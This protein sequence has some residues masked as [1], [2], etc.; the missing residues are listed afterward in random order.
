MQRPASRSFSTTAG[1]SCKLRSCG[2]AELRPE[3]ALLLLKRS[4]RSSRL[5]KPG[6]RLQRCGCF[7]SEPGKLENPLL[8]AHFFKTSF[9]QLQIF[10]RLR[11]TSRG[12]ALEL[13]GTA[14]E[15]SSVRSEMKT[16]S[17]FT[18]A[19]RG[20]SPTNFHRSVLA[21]YDV[22]GLMHEFLIGCCLHVGSFDA[23]KLPSLA[24]AESFCQVC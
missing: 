5:A 22:Y 15:E 24:L 11:A 19:L 2:A 14:S 8:G 21:V 9:M 7:A 13:R 10:L 1:L 16:L 18:Q 6:S 23:L 3:T 12:R 20:S 4:F 17:I